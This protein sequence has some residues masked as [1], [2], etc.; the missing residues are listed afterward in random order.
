MNL[1][2]E[3]I[4]GLIIFLIILVVLII[5]T[6]IPRAI[7]EQIDKQQELR[8]CCK[9]YVGNGCPRFALTDYSNITNII[10]DQN[11]PTSLEDLVAEQS[12]SYDSLKIFCN[13]P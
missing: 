2:M 4:I 9:P 8:K 3:K 6:N 1:A 5:F 10:C 13:C 7:G 11:V 12:M